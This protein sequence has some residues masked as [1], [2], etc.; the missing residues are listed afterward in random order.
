MKMAGEKAQMALRMVV[1]TALMAILATVGCGGG[2][3]VLTETMYCGEPSA[4]IYDAG[5]VSVSANGD[6]LLE[7]A[8]LPD[9]YWTATYKDPRYL[10]GP[11]YHVLDFCPDGNI[12]VVGDCA[13]FSDWSSE[14][15]VG[16][17]DGNGAPLPGWPK[18]YKGPQRSWNEGQDVTVDDAGN[19]IVTGYA[20]LWRL[21][22]EGN[23][24]PGWPQY[25]M[26][27]SSISTAVILDTAGDIIACGTTAWE[28]GQ[29]FVLKKYRA[30]GSVV[31]GW[32]KSY[33][34]DGSEEN[35]AYDLLQD[36]DGNLVVCGYTQTAGVRAALL[37]KLDAGGNVLP[38]W[39][40][41]WSSGSGGYDEYFKVAQDSNGN[42]CLVGITGA[43]ESSGRLL[44]T[45]YSAGGE[46]LTDSGWPQVYDHNGLRDASPPDAWGGG[47]DRLGNIAAAATCQSDTNISTVKYTDKAAMASGFPKVMQHPGYYEVTRS[48]SVDEQGN[49]YTVGYWEVDDGSHADYT[50]FIV[51]YPPGRYSDTRPSAVFKEGICYTG[52]AGFS[53]TLGP[54]NQG[55]V[56]YQLSPDR[57][58]WYYNDGSEWRMATTSRE[59]NT[60]EE[61]NA[62][63]VDY[64][65]KIG[66]GTL[67]LRVF[68][69]SDGTQRVQLESITV[70]Y[71][72]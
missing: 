49:I 9:A 16:K 12:V 5:L 39:P 42:Y 32:P 27:D 72:S 20:V 65:E 29:R 40:K 25:F 35:F 54:E 58:N 46:Q 43:S 23:V 69:V 1:T 22:A 8:E 26:G 34:I 11:E 61:I 67:Y 63:I 59:A 52:L 50:T 68:L 36:T 24:L 66:P 41:T 18:F 15:I 55:S 17:Y 64:A 6:P 33:G 14:V 62:S 44:V 13:H 31:E 21:D 30:D 28:G 71:K 3:P 37:Y 51:K 57:E 45:R 47:V 70:S 4:L 10:A 19:I 7:L 38:G 48:C 2:K 56:L 53:E 60:A